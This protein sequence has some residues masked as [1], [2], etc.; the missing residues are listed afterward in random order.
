[1]RRVGKAG[2]MCR[3]GRQLKRVFGV[4]EKESKGLDASAAFQMLF[5]SWD[6]LLR[7]QWSW[8]YVYDVYERHV[9]S[10]VQDGINLKE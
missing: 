8:R 2:R 1:M 6:S 4:G 3:L 9:G 10:N 5:V 7:V